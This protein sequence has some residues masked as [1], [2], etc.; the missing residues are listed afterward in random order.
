MISHYEQNAC[1]TPLLNKA[2]DKRCISLQKSFENL[3][4]TALQLSISVHWKSNLT[5][6]IMQFSL[7]K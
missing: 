2:E 3:N 4:C 6:M 1:H 5:F 7:M